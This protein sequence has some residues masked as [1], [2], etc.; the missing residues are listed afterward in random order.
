[1]LA[2]G[3]RPMR[4]HDTAGGNVADMFR[5]KYELPGSFLKASSEVEAAA[6]LR[7]VLAVMHRTDRTQ[8][9]AGGSMTVWRK[10]DDEM[11]NH[12]I[13]NGHVQRAP[14]VEKAI[15]VYG[16]IHTATS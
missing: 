1:M 15:R 12:D 7:T 2:F 16:T 11:E 14:L 3:R 5:R 8:H 9:K 4:S 13:T 6:R 10:L